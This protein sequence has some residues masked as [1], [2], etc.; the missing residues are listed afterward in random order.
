MKVKTEY[1]P[2]GCDYLT[3]GKEYTAK[4]YH[5][6]ADPNLLLIFDDDGEEIAV[7]VSG[8]AFLDGHPWTII[9]D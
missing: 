7:R 3:A 1:V 5:Y 9:E 6:S 8:C 4:Y 2:D